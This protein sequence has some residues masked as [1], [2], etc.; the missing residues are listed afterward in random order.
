MFYEPEPQ[1]SAPEPP[2]EPTPPDPP[3]PPSEP[4]AVKPPKPV[5]QKPI[6][7]QPKSVPDPTYETFPVG[8]HV[9]RSELEGWQWATLV[10]GVLA[11]LFLILSVAT[12]AGCSRRE[13]ELKAIYNTNP[14]LEKQFHK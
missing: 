12:G 10:A 4:V 5:K 6:S 9:P 8:E 2:P 13:Q 11:T 7:P 3:A 1:R 14:H